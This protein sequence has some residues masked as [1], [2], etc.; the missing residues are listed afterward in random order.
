MVPYID[1]GN[2]IAISIGPIVDKGNISAVYDF[3]TLAYS[4]AVGGNIFSN[5]ARQRVN[6]CGDNVFTVVIRK[7]VGFIHRR[8]ERRKIA[9]FGPFPDGIATV[10]QVV[11][12][13]DGLGLGGECPQ[14][15][16]AVKKFLKHDRQY[17]SLVPVPSMAF[18]PRNRVSVISFSVSNIRFNV[19]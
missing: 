14:P 12:P 8:V 15:I 10:W 19:S 2:R 16:A 7:V 4:V 17:Y 1:H 9:V 18:E 11:R 3:E 13:A 6:I 5:Q